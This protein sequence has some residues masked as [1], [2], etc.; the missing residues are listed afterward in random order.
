[1]LTRDSTS[2]YIWERFGSFSKRCFCFFS[3]FGNFPV[4]KQFL[5]LGNRRES[6]S[7]TGHDNPNA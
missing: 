2:F 1:M 7:I 6:K 5:I 4:Y 3:A